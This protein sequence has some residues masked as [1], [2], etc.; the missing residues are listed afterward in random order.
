VLGPTHPST[1]RTTQRLAEMYER[2]GKREK[3]AEWRAKLSS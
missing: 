1:N 2:W 3:A